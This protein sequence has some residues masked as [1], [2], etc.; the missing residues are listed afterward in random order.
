VTPSAP[1][2]H[3]PSSA[4]VEARVAE[5]GRHDSWFAVAVLDFDLARCCRSPARYTIAYVHLLADVK[6]VLVDLIATLFCA[7]LV[8]AAF[9]DAV[10]S[11]GC[12]IT[13]AARVV[14]IDLA[15]CS[16][17]D[18]VITGAG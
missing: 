3:L 7:I 5:D 17:R 12:V 8:N 15:S 18:I 11:L 4:T 6:G 2:S 9:L 13:T 10:P 1:P 16:R 14:H